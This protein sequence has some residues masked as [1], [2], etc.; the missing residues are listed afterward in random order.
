MTE[1]DQLKEKTA[2]NGHTQCAARLAAM[3]QAARQV[4]N[5]TIVAEVVETSITAE[6][7]PTGNPQQQKSS[8]ESSEQGP[9]KTSTSN[10]KDKN[11]SPKNSPDSGNFSLYI[12]DHKKLNQI[13]EETVESCFLSANQEF[14]NYD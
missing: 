11:K 8:K 1:L 6:N 5:P 13:I 3:S 12:S 4:I 14:V 7:G 2:R 9:K 10:H